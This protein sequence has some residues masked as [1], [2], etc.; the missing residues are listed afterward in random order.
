VIPHAHEKSESWTHSG[1]TSLVS[2][3]AYKATCKIINDVTRVAIPLDYN[4]EKTQRKRVF[5][6]FFLSLLLPRD[7]Y[8][9][10]MI[11]IVVKSNDWSAMYDQIIKHSHN[12]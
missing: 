1:P 6:L 5:S 7:N 11:T 2:H 12:A 3:H 8:Q 10:T 9:T 4:P